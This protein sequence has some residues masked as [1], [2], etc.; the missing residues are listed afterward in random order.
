MYGG[1]ADEGRG[2]APGEGDEEDGD[3]PAEGG[4]GGV[5]HWVGCGAEVR[6]GWEG[7][8]KLERGGVRFEGGR[9]GWIDGRYGGGTGD[10]TLR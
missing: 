6:R 10:W 7:E 8:R 5:V 9:S 4:G 2:E 3:G 1:E